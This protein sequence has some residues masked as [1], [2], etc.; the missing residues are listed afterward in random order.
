LTSTGVQ[1]NYYEE[2]EGHSSGQRSR[3]Y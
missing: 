3:K 1:F 2:T